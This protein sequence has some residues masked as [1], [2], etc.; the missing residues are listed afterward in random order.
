MTPLEKNLCQQFDLQSCLTGSQLS[1]NILEFTVDEFTT[2][3]VNS[4]N[5]SDGFFD[6]DKI[7]F[8]EGFSSLGFTSHKQFQLHSENHDGVFVFGVLAKH[9]NTAGV[10]S[11]PSEFN[12]LSPVISFMAKDFAKNV[13]FSDTYMCGFMLR[14][15]PLLPTSQIGSK[16]HCHK[17]FSHDSVPVERIDNLEIPT[18]TV[19]ML[20]K[21]AK[22]M[23][24]IEYLVSDRLGTIIQNTQSAEK[25][26]ISEDSGAYTLEE[27]LAKSIARTAMDGEILRGS[28]YA[29][30]AA[31]TVPEHMIGDTRV[32]LAL[33]FTPTIYTRDA[34]L[35]LVR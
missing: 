20:D 24:A 29:F 6:N 19:A 16:Y 9:P 21:T 14:Q 17:I 4:A 23:V 1:T 35:R 11:L 25:L 13:P 3:T 22:D 15:V 30:H 2:T 5:L 18:S 8:G 12:Y 10:F 31:S 28:S 7:A 27:P 26:N 32:L 33:S 34:H